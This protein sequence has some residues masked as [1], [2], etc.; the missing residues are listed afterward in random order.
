MVKIKRKTPEEQ[1]I[2]ELREL[3]RHMAELVATMK[4]LVRLYKR[5]IVEIEEEF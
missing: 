2:Q 4:E 1:I 5:Q 3:N